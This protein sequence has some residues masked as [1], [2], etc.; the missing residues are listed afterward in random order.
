MEGK[1][2]K[3]PKKIIRKYEREVSNLKT[4]VNWHKNELEKLMKREKEL[5][6]LTKNLITYQ[7][8]ATTN[9]KAIK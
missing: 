1:Y 5:K 7:K 4:K 6:K 9:L 2:C 8:L 3:I